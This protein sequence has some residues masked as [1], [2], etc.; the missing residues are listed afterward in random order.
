MAIDLMY[1][2]WDWHILRA[3]IAERN[4][5]KAARSIEQSKFATQ[6][7]KRCKRLA[8]KMENQDECA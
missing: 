5:A 7:P 2:L 3:A 8:Q 1:E 4:F 6:A